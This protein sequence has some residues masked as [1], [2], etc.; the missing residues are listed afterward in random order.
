M[1]ALSRAAVTGNNIQSE[2]DQ[3]WS[4]RDCAPM[5]NNNSALEWQTADHTCVSLVAYL[6]D[7]TPLPQ[8]AHRRWHSWLPKLLLL[9]GILY[10][11][12]SPDRLQL[13]VP[14]ANARQVFDMFNSS[15]SGGH[16]GLQKTYATLLQKYTWPNMKKD[17]EEWCRTCLTCQAAKH[18]NKAARAPLENI[19][20]GSLMEIIGVDIM[21]PLPLT[22][23]GNRY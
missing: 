4:G 16:Y 6:T 10:H 15:T 23:T 7:G 1:D 5:L 3:P 8:D 12:A 9:D 11:Q 13:L 2:P 19:R 14:P 21:G 18:L 17:L 22:A 20:V